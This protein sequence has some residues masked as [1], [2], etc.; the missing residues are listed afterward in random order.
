L[1]REEHFIIFIHRSNAFIKRASLFIQ[2]CTDPEK[3]PLLSFKDFDE[4]LKADPTNPDVYFHRGQVKTD[5]EL[6]INK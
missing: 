4:A 1:I 2:Q 3:D 6:F 5:L